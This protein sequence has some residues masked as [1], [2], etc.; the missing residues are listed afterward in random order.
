[1]KEN[2]GELKRLSDLGNDNNWVNKWSTDSKT[3]EEV[4]AGLYKGIKVQLGEAEDAIGKLGYYEVKNEKGEVVGI[5]D[6]T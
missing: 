2:R 6:N 5:I 4:D 1:M 3:F